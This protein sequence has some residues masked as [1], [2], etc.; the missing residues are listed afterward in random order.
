MLSS[1]RKRTRAAG[2]L[3]P[4][5]RFLVIAFTVSAAGCSADV[6]RFDLGSKNS[7][8]SI[9]IPPEPVRTGYGPSASP[10][11]LGLTEAPLPPSELTD[12]YRV[13]GRQYDA[14]PSPPSFADRTPPP[15]TPDNYRVVGRQYKSRPSAPPLSPSRRNRLPAPMHLSVNLRLKPLAVPSTSSPAKRSTALAVVMGFPPRP[16]RTPT[17]CRAIRSVPAS[18]WSCPQERRTT[19][20][21]SARRR[22][23][24]KT[25]PLSREPHLPRPLHRRRQASTHPP[26]TH[27][28]AG[29]AATP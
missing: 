25:A 20:H 24:R 26:A 14:P 7:T 17:D 18:A 27:R 2:V 9:P 3:G 11:G 29:R 13:A 15:E 4:I 23:Y 8:S 10:R 12:N 5:A 16:S 22:L 21:L 19:A 28:P 1:K 6:T